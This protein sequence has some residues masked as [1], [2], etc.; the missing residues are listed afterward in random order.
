MKTSLEIH[1]AQK[2]RDR[3]HHEE[4]VAWLSVELPVYADGAPVA[5]LHVMN[6]LKASRACLADTTGMT[7]YNTGPQEGEQ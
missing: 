7:G 1:E 5:G 6:W 3:K 2:A 4:R